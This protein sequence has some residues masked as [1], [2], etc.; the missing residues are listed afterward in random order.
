MDEEYCP[1]C[2]KPV[3]WIELG[4]HNG[5]CKVCYDD[6]YFGGDVNDEDDT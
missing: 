1:D 5:V 2:G 6:F 4:M 3:E